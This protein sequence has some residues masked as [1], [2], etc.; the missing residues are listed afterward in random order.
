MTAW[1]PIFVVLAAAPTQPTDEL[2][3]LRLCAAPSQGRAR[4]EAPSGPGEAE[5]VQ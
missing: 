3:P 2:A 5:A 1:I 4:K